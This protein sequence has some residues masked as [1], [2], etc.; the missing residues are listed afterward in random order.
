MR[1]SI[2]NFKSQTAQF[3]ATADAIKASWQD[4]VGDAFYRDIIRPLKEAADQLEPAMQA[5]PPKLEQ[6]KTQ[7]DAI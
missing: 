2:S 6:I 1:Q 4:N 7:I 5:L 3:S